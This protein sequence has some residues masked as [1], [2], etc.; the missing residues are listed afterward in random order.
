MNNLSNITFDNIMKYLDNSDRISFICTNFKT[1]YLGYLS[2][3]HHGYIKYKNYYKHVYI[4]KLIIK[5]YISNEEINSIYGIKE[6]KFVNIKNNLLKHI[7]LPISLTKLDFNIIV[8]SEITDFTPLKY[9]INLEEL[10]INSFIDNLILKNISLPNSLKIFNT[11][12][13]YIKPDVLYNLQNLKILSIIYDRNSRSKNNIQQLKIPPNINKLFIVNAILHNYDFLNK[14][15]NLS[16]LILNNSTI[17]NLIN[18]NLPSSLYILGLVNGYIYY[19]Y[20]E[21]EIY[22]EFFSKMKNIKYL[23]IDK[24]LYKYS[25]ILTECNIKI[26]NQNKFKFFNLNNLPNT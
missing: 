23:Y 25:K 3:Y 19:S 17:T 13:V 1:L 11:D 5:N 8:N 21:L 7:S 2:K 26:L 6:I 12:A 4:K 15:S 9:L 14:L 24:Y 22:N 16:V 20:D 18:I 10:H